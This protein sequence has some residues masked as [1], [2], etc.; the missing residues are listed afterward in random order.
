VKM[1]DCGSR[2]LS[3]RNIPAVRMATD[4]YGLEFMSRVGDKRWCGW[5]ELVRGEW[6]PLEGGVFSTK[7]EGEKNEL[8][9][10]WNQGRSTP[11]ELWNGSWQRE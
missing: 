8:K 11:C 9:K 4:L 10:D 2:W 5:K 6:S 1:R 3:A 7:K